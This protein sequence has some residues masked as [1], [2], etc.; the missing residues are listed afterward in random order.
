MRSTI[1]GR[2]LLASACL[3]FGRHLWGQLNGPESQASPRLEVAVL[4]D[5][6]LSNVVR[7][8]RFWMQGGSIQVDGQFWH[9]LCAEADI[10]GFH[11][12]NA[13]SA[14]V[15]L[16]MVTT[17]FGPRY[18]WSPVHHRYSFFSHA[19]VGEANGFNSIFPGAGSASSSTNGLAL[20]LGGGMDLLVRHRLLMRVFEAD[21]LRTEMPNGDTNVQNNVRLAAGVVVRFR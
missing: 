2:L 12:Q 14:G 9:G 8:D 19:L 6:L 3:I 17:T 13:N 15:G 4:Y 7:A 20:Q 10:S 16:D 21:W 18:R 11:A 5:S 1:R